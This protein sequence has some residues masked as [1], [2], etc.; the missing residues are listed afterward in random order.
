M[1]HHCC[2][3]IIIYLKIAD[4]FNV[5]YFKVFINKFS[6]KKILFKNFIYKY[7]ENIQ[8]SIGT[9]TNNL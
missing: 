2:Q 7:L 3:D 1:D 4:I 5:M 6:W 8:I 9:Y